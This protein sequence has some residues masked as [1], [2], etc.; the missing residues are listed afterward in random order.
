M[1]R[2]LSPASTEH[3]KH[4]SLEMGHNIQVA[5]LK[6][7]SPFE[8]FIYTVVSSC[9]QRNVELIKILGCNF[10]DFEFRILMVS[11][12]IKRAK[13]DPSKF[14][15]QF[16]VFRNSFVGNFFKNRMMSNNLNNI[17]EKIFGTL[18]VKNIFG[19]YIIVL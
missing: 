3:G 18:I 15:Q 11:F 7:C 5:H 2:F 6:F 1:A 17:L 14:P 19:L 13:R 4:N 9:V 10:N 8:H 12:C 16:F